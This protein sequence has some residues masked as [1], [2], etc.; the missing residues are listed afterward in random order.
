MFIEYVL[1]VALTVYTEA[2]SFLPQ[3][4]PLRGECFHITDEETEAYR[5]C[6]STSEVGAWF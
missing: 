4:S 1:D 2:V 5:G 3:S 6:H